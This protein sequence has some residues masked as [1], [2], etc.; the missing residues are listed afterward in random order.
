MTDVVTATLSNVAAAS[1]SG[2]GA[3]LSASSV[4][5]VSSTAILTSTLA[6]T[7]ISGVVVTPVRTSAVVTVVPS[8]VKPASTVK[9]TATG[10]LATQSADHNTNKLAAGAVAGIVIGCLLF[11]VAV[12]A[13]VAIWRR[14]REESGA[15]RDEYGDGY[16]G[17]SHDGMYEKTNHTTNLNRSGTTHSALSFSDDP[18][19]RP[20]RSNAGWNQS[21]TGDGGFLS[22]PYGAPPLPPVQRAVQPQPQP[23]PIAVRSRD[24][25]YSNN[26]D[27]SNIERHAYDGMSE[28]AHSAA[29]LQVRANDDIRLTQF[30]DWMQ[31]ENGLQPAN[32]HS[33]ST[34]HIPAQAQVGLALSPPTSSAALAHHQAYDDIYDTY[35]NEPRASNGPWLRSTPVPVPV[36]PVQLVQPHYGEVSHA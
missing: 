24:S 32:P 33:G 31:Y 19:D 7:T 18:V 5:L 9:T 8:T 10:V 16:E 36:S 2:S 4:T 1:P 26:S 20:P 27:Y 14:K 13:F 15:Y 21:Y 23:E 34:E 29:P 3:S 22:V 25:A 17:T 35:A 12:Y 30:D 6:P 11:L 28:D